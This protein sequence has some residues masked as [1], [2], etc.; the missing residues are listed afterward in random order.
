MKL[1]TKMIIGY[2]SIILLTG[3]LGVFAIVML[4]RVNQMSTD[5]AVNWMPSVYYSSELNAATSDY[6]I[7]EFQHVVSFIESEMQEYERQL[8]AKAEHIKSIQAKYEPLI[9]SQAEQQLYNQFK[10]EWNAYL[11]EH[12]KVLALS[13]E[14][15][16]E[17][18]KVG[19]RSKSQDTFN[20]FDKTIK[21][22]AQLNFDSGVA[23]S[24]AGDR[25]YEMSRLLIG[26]VLLVA[27]VGAF[28]IALIQTRGLL[29]QLGGDP[30]VVA[31]IARQ[32]AEGDLTIELRLRKNQK[33]SVLAAMQQMASRL[34]DVVTQV[35]Q[36]ADN[37]AS[38]SRQ[39]SSNAEEMS[40]GVAEQAASS[41]EASASME[42]MASNIKQNSDNAVQTEKI[43]VKAAEDARQSGDAVAHTVAAMQELV[44]KISMIEEIAR[45]THI[46]SLNAT[47]EA[48]KAQEYGKGFAVVAAEVR[49]LATRAQDAAVEITGVVKTSVNIAERAGDLLK[50]L[51]PDIQRTAELVQEINAASKEQS[52]GTGQINKAILQL[53]QVTQQNSA[54]A[55]EM[56]STADELASQAEQLQDAIAFFNVAEEEDDEADEE[57]V[58]AAPPPPPP[59]K[60]GKRSKNTPRKVRKP[61]VADED[62]ES[63]ELEERETATP[64]DPKRQ[65]KRRENDDIDDEFERY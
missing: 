31:A 8:Q 39:L 48:A 6:R 49:S 61:A 63:A 36:T 37:V 24:N 51:V 3:F 56:A 5:I 54:A 41:E 32:V 60:N 10:D 33:N 17:E 62:Q 28:V 27:V 4:A 11:R 53:D 42:Q 1:R 45:M 44:P 13:K 2:T 15:K 50:K 20:A 22:I 35:Q 12:E 25:M 57:E 18:A 14:N 64:P 40:Q 43:A 38:G 65:N 16:T 46:L 58:V 30:S 26:V 55:E 7:L 59:A 47:I 21:Q 34:K 23:A 52:S 9:S 19:L 29:R